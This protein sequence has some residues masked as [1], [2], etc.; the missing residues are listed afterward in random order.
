MPAGAVLIFGSYLA[1]RSGPNSSQKPRAAIYATYNGMSEGDKHDSYYAHRR[2]LWPPNSERVEGEKYHE[3]A[4]IY[5]F[6]SPMAVGKE[7]I[8]EVLAKGDQKAIQDKVSQIFDILIAQGDADYIGEPISQL[9]HCLQAAQLAVE[10]KADDVTVAAALLHDIGQFLPSST[11][12]AVMTNGGSVGRTGHE[13][14]GE[15]YLRQLGMSS[16]VCELVGAHVVAKRY[17]TAS[18]PGYYESLSD[19]SKASLKHQGGPYDPEQVQEFL[20]DPLWE[21]KVQL[22]QWDDQAKR[23][24]LDLAKVGLEAFR[25]VVERAWVAERV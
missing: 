24:D 17:L 20:K 18:V 22:R 4:M 6:G 2:K 16:V 1:H 21:Q 10:A 9:E 3:G 19:A 8:A 13:Q 14:I 25:P 15:T 11:A 5:A 7:A 12:K 23:T